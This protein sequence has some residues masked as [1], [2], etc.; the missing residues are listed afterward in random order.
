MPR[1]LVYEFICGGA[2]A[3]QP[4][5]DSL[6]AE[7]WAMLSAVIE[8]LSAIDGT[9][10]WTTVDGRINRLLAAEVK[11]FRPLEERDTLLRLASNCDC[12]LV[13]APET[14][15]ALYERAVWLADSPARWI[16]CSPSAIELTADKFK[17]G[18]HLKDNAIPALTVRPLLLDAL[19]EMEL[20][21]VIKPREGAGSENT[22]LV[23][24]PDELRNALS[25][26]NPQDGGLVHQPLH[27]GEPV[28]V[29]FQCGPAGLSAL[30]PC[31]QRLS[32]DGRFRYLGGRVPLVEDLAVRATSLAARAL[33]CL[34]GLSG[35]VGV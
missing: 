1:I 23:R 14:D 7:G 30:P 15:G 20:P 35:H 18:N 19:E 5:P 13:I 17:L 10:V 28:S 12:V 9:E 11:E 34:D 29:A 26:L 25:L 4:L 16:G 21:A 24:S 33:R 31:S 6:A 32:D 2:L 3:D 22:F 8:D 27:P